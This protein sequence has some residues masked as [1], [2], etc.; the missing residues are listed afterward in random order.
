M[1]LG[2]P[3][4]EDATPVGRGAFATVYRA[5]QPAFRRTVAVK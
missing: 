4:L 1:D 2:I 3:G 5:H